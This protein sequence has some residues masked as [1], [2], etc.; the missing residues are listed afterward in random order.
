M[1]RLRRSA[2]LAITRVA[3]AW[4]AI[5]LPGFRGSASVDAAASGAQAS[6]SIT[7]TNVVIAPEGDH[8]TVT[9]E[10]DGPLP[11]PTVGQLEAPPR[12]FM[13]FAGVSATTRGG[14]AQ[15]GAHV[16][17]V[18][19]ALFSSQ[20]RVTRVVVDL[21]QQEPIRTEAGDRQ[22]GR[23][24]VVIG[25]AAPAAAP[26]EPQPARPQPAGPPIAPVPALPVPS[27]VARP[28]PVGTSP[29][30]VPDAPPGV[31]PSRP[32]EPPPP[33]RDLEQYREQVEPALVRLRE[34]RPLLTAIDRREV[35]PPENLGGAREA[36]SG[37]LRTLTTVRAPEALK[38]THDLLLRSVSLALMAAT[39]REDAGTRADPDKMRNAGSAAAG[40]LL[41]LDR[42]CT[43]LNVQCGALP[44][45]SA[46]R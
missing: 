31:F 46:G 22:A 40:A 10:A 5:A 25:A 3:L 36:L 30:P 29:P 15:E 14:A 21:K 7:I 12:F 43:A 24:K 2:A 6:S 39:L 17:R 37:V 28:D 8:T 11:V 45:P 33:A 4:A 1:T 35:K 41:L 44:A 26:P 19:V 38:G 23:F 16:V 34:V 20:P 13:D 32:P 27:G 18:R 42:V 9:I